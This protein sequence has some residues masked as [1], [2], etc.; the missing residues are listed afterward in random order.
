MRGKSRWDKLSDKLS[1]KMRD[2]EVPVGDIF[3]FCLRGCVVVIVLLSGRC[4]FLCQTYVF[5]DEC[6]Q[7]LSV[8]QNE[9]F[10]VDICLKDTKL[11]FK[12]TCKTMQY[13]NYNKLY[14]ALMRFSQYNYLYSQLKSVCR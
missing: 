11:I 7:K 6:V 3:S 10:S 14:Y 12:G 2:K 8:E 4:V 13:N 1:D 5:D 9:V